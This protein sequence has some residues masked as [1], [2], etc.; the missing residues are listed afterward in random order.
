MLKGDV[1]ILLAIEVRRIAAH[2]AFQPVIFLVVTG[3]SGKGVVILR[4]R[5]GHTGCDH[6]VFVGFQRLLWIARLRFK[7]RTVAQHH[8]AFHRRWLRFCL[9]DQ[10]IKRLLRRCGIDKLCL[11]QRHAPLSVQR[12]VIGGG[13]FRQLTARR[14][15][16]ACGNIHFRQ[17]KNGIG[18]IRLPRQHILIRRAGGGVIA[19][20]LCPVSQRKIN[21]R[22][23]RLLA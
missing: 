9:R 23:R 6:R 14:G 11:H 12:G 13:K 22:G 10:L 3:Q 18:V 17:A 1:K 20:L 16:V 8:R 4:T 21:A 2:A 19:S 7:L 15:F 5:R